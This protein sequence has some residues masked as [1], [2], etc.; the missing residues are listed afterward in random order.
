[1][2]R[3]LLTAALVLALATGCAGARTGA[4][5]APATSPPADSGVQGHTMVDGGCPMA[6][7]SDCPD[8]PLPAKLTVTRTGESAPVATATSGSDGYFRIALPPGRYTL[9]PANLTGAILP[10][11]T[12]ADVRVQPGEY[13]TVTVSFDSGIR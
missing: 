6:K 8:K 4:P 1:M 10:A 11:A 2:T 13:T 12:A 3:L 5:S 9:R 7:D